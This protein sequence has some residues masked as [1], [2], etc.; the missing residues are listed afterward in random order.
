VRGCE[1][2]SSPKRRRAGE[3]NAPKRCTRR[4]ES[5]NNRSCHTLGWRTPYTLS[6]LG[7]HD[8]HAEGLAG[9]LALVRTPGLR[10]IHLAG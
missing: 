8:T 3:W 2:K 6:G 1:S 5:R 9:L 7:D 10:Y 4:S